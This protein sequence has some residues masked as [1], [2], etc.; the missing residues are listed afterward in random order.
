MQAYEGNFCISSLDTLEIIPLLS[1]PTT[2]HQLHI[3]YPSI[4]YRPPGRPIIYR[5]DLAVFKLAVKILYSSSTSP[6]NSSYFSFS[7][8]SEPYNTFNQ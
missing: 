8:N 2:R 4:I 6:I 3:I 1:Y 5:F 7:I